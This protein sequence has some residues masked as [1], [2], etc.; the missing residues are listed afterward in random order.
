MKISIQYS[1]QFPTVIVKE[2]QYPTKI[3]ENQSSNETGS[4]LSLDIIGEFLAC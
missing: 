2:N 4:F 3:E 1:T